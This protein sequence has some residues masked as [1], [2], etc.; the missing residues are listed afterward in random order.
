MSS[1]I[2]FSEF[3]HFGKK[4][5]APKPSDSEKTVQV[6]CVTLEP[7]ENEKELKNEAGDG[8]KD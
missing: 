8:E 2:S 6:I 7:N 3:F 1:A 5:Q 4:S